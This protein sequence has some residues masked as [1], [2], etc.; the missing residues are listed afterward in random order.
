MSTINLLNHQIETMCGR[1]SELYRNTSTSAISTTEAIPI[2]LKELGVASEELQVVMEE[3]TRQ[4]EALTLAQNSIRNNTDRYQALFEF[5]PDCLLITNAQ[6]T[7]QEANRAATSLMSRKSAHF[8]SGKPLISLIAIHDRDFV[9]AKLTQLTHCNHLEFT[10]HLSTKEGLV[11]VRFTVDAIEIDRDGRIFRWQVKPVAALLKAADSESETDLSSTLTEV[12]QKG[13]LI[14]L[15]SGMIWQVVHG[16]VK[17]TT[18]SQSGDEIMVGAVTEGMV[19]GSGLTLL[20]TYSAI[21]LSDVR[22]LPIP[23]HKVRQSPDLA[24]QLLPRILERLQQTEAFLAVAGHLHVHDRIEQ[25]L[26]LLKQS[27]GQPCDKG[28]RLRIRFTHQELAN[29]CSTTRVTMTRL[30]GKLQQQ[31]KI[32][33]DSQNHLVLCDSSLQK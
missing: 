3:L 22:L 28:T 14:P 29:A 31:G 21:A 17:L 25:L 8:L 32:Y 20:Q 24:Y 5:A 1:L 9:R 16:V 26:S 12:Y 4:N 2:A 30:L 13:E 7:I 27:L 15:D 19:F 33:F 18:L 6:G 23:L 10:A 11:N